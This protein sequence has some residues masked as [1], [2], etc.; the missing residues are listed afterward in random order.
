MF[1][2]SSIYIYLY[3]YILYVCKCTELYPYIKKTCLYISMCKKMF[4]RIYSDQSNWPSPPHSS[5]AD[6][7]SLP[8]PNSFVF[9][10]QKPSQRLQDWWAIISGHTVHPGARWLKQ[11]DTRPLIAVLHC[12]NSWLGRPQNFRYRVYINVPV[13]IGTLPSTCTLQMIKS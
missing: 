9:F 7:Y 13:L 4:I 5:G 1:M 10:A 6:I 12:Q 3:I 8:F 2:Y 11:W